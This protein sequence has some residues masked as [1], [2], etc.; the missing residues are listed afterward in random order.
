M[1]G[2]STHSP[3]R[4]PNE[5]LAGLAALKVDNGQEVI[6]SAPAWT[7]WLACGQCWPGVVRLTPHHRVTG[8]VCNV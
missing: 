1:G 7:L 2:S 4:R 8:G 6:V 5:V 3:L